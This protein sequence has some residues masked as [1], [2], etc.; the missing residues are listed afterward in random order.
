MLTPQ[1]MDEQFKLTID[2]TWEKKES[3]LD[4]FLDTLTRCKEYAPYI[5]SAMGNDLPTIISG[6]LYQGYL[7]GLADRAPVKEKEEVTVA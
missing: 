3:L 4:S 1:Q 7:M 5:L 6:T 2:G